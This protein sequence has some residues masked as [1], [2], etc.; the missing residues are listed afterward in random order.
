MLT[1][2][3]E[4]SADPVTRITLAITV[5]Y[6]GNA[7]PRVTWFDAWHWTARGN[8][9]KRSEQYTDKV[10][11]FDTNPCQTS[12]VPCSDYYRR[13]RGRG[14]MWSGTW[15]R[16][17]SIE[18]VG[19]LITDDRTKLFS[20]VEKRCD[21]EQMKLPNGLFSCVAATEAICT[22]ANDGARRPE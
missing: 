18:M 5:E 14:F 3:I 7:A 21:A 4:P 17:P 22:R 13:Y 15:R 8:V 19:A 1:K 11:T 12:G 9:F 10:A 20:Y 2:K 16:D 6:Q